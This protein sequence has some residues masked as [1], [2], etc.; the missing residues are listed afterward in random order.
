MDPMDGHLDA[1]NRHDLEAFLSYYAPDVVTEDGTG[2]VMIQG[3]DTMR[4]LYST[5]FAQSPDLRAEVVTRIRVGDYVIFE[6]HITGLV[7][8]GYPSEMHA[9]VIAR[10]NGQLIEHVRILT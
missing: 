5:L 1:Y 8:E 3:H 6:E 9:V 7:M 4:Q 10:L 2:Q